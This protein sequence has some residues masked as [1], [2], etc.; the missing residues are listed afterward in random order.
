MRRIFLLGLTIVLTASLI[1]ACQQEKSSV[2][3]ATPTDSTALRLALMPTMSCLPFYYAEQMGIYDSL[4]LNVEI[5]PFNAQFD[6]DSALLGGSVDVAATDLLRL[7]YYQKRSE[8]LVA[9]MSLADSWSLVVTEKNPGKTLRKIGNQTLACSRFSASD[10]Y[11]RVALL[12]AGLDTDTVFRPQINNLFLRTTMLQN[13]Q[14]DAAMLPEPLATAAGFA[15]ARR[16]YTSSVTDTIR[17]TCIAMRPARLNQEQKDILIKGYN[18]SAELID[19]RKDNNLSN[20]LQ[21]AYKLHPEVCDSLR[22]PIPFPKAIQ[23]A[24]ISWQAARQTF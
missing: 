15:G 22:L 4:G 12:G 11:S 3:V 21:N 1:S 8:K 17:M 14:V 9:F 7:Q 18:K 23:P 13:G 20:I 5:V 6:C 19:I 10:Y 24:A 2:P 16:L